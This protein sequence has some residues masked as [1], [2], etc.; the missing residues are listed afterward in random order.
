[1]LPGGKGLLFRVRRAGQPPTE[2]DIFVKPLPDGEARPLIRGLYARYA[3]S[4]HLLVVTADGKLL[5]VP[6]DPRS[7]C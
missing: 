2:F 5:A 6:F 4:G 3:A 7:W 1:M